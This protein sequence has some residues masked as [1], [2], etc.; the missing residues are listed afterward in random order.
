[1]TVLA[2]TPE[3]GPLLSA[4]ATARRRQAIRA[5]STSTLARRRLAGKIVPGLCLVALLVSLAPLIVLVGYTV[6]RGVPALSVA[7]FTNTARPAGVPGGGIAGA[8][9]GTGVIL[10]IALCMAIPVGLLAALFLVERQGALAGAVRFVADVLSGIPSIAI[11]VFAYAVFVVPLGHYAGVFGSCAL[12]VLMLPIIIRANEEAM[13]TVP[14]DLWEAGLALGARRARVVRRVV[15]RGALGGIVTANLLAL[16]RAVGETAPLFFTVLGASAFNLSP[17]G[18][19]NALPL[20]IFNDA[21]QVSPD[22]QATAWGTA[23]VLL[24]FVL[25]LSVLARF[26]AGRFTR[27]AR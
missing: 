25:V 27:L 5:A 7:F 21:N 14:E 13:R 18:P 19:Q 8:L 26:V 11:G 12:A 16:A 6:S 3:A 24:A 22:L 10:G 1:M 9:A 2:G 23:L 20:E 4:E 15:L 17:L